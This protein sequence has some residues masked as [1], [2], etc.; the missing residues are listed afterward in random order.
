MS[1]LWFVLRIAVIAPMIVAAL[2]IIATCYPFMGVR[3]RSLANRTWSRMLLA[4]CGIAVEVRGQPVYEAPV[5]WVS[6]HVSWLDI[7]VLNSVRATAFVAKAEIRRW[8][9]LGWL[10]AGA[11]TVFLDRKQRHAVQHASEAMRR[12][13]DRGEVVGL[14]PEGTTSNGLDVQTFYP[15]LFEPARLLDVAIQPVALRFLHQGQRSG[16]AA[17]VGEETLLEN[18]WRVLRGT[19]VKVEAVF[20]PPLARQDEQGRVYTRVELATRAHAM[21]REQVVAVTAT[22]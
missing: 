19:G 1:V 11:G 13:F 3:S 20:L 21:V 10:V 5:L 18:A 12:R 15:S 14:F 4:V 2:L 6:N 22:R 16:F 8:P 7:Y 9:V 17:F